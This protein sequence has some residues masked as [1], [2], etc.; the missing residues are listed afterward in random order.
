MRIVLFGSSDFSIPTLRYLHKSNN[1][2]VAVVTPFDKPKGRGKKLIP[3]NFSKCAIDKK[4]NIIRIKNFN[5][6][7]I[8]SELKLLKADIFVVVAF[9]KI[10]DN[11]LNIPRI[12]SMNIH[13]SLLPKYRGAA[14]LQWAIM[15][16]DKKIGISIIKLSSKIDAGNILKQK[17]IDFKDEENFGDLHDKTSKIGAE[18]LIET[19]DIFK[20]NTLYQGLEQDNKLVTLARKLKKTDYLINWYETSTKIKN[21]IRAFSPYP[22]SYTI[23]DNKRFKIF[24]VEYY[25]FDKDLITP[26]SFLIK[27]DRLI[28]K[29]KDSFLSILQVQMEGKNK[30]AIKD[31]LSGFK[32]SE[33]KFA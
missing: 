8:E 30:L 31:F 22:G 7:N 25:D 29:T 26:G 12:C 32:F 19:I 13:P 16:G 11:I 1:Q 28:V 33:Y 20:L 27:D 10:P 6:S 9:Q 3:S 2:L 4:C 18:L 14:P 21:K 15:N 23:L 24:E 5:D 17:T